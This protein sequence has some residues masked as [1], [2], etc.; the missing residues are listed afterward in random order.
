MYNIH[1]PNIPNMGDQLNK[2]MLEELFKI[3]VRSVSLRKRNIIAIGSGMS[4]L[5]Y[6]S[7]KQKRF[8]QS[9]MY[10]F[11]PEIH[12][13]GTGFISYSEKDNDFVNK[14]VIIHA[15]RGELS[16]KRVEKILKKRIDVPLGDGGLLVEKWIGNSEK[17][18]YKVGIIPHF[19]EKDYPL[20]NKIR[21][22]Y[23]DSI[24][25]DL[26]DEPKKVVEQISKC[27]VILSSSL[28]GLIVADSFHIPNK[29]IILYTGEKRILGDGFKFDDYYSAFG[30]NDESIKMEKENWPSVEE[31][32]E[33]YRISPIEVEKKKAE[34]IKAFP[35]L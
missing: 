22:S 16:K 31:I 1:Y 32:I 12:V 14:K 25:I 10:P 29:H 15:L 13:W 27:E 7:D 33:S 23:E 30:L 26:G 20:L 2:C 35:S 34:L 8:I 5:L 9:L 19:R 18:E 11:S 3:N 4:S 21:D 24:I 6:S 28:H 17:K